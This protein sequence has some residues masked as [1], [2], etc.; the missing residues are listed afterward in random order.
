MGE[1]TSTRHA[2]DQ[3]VVEVAVPP[4]LRRLLT[5]ADRA[6]PPPPT[7]R[8]DAHAASPQPHR[9]PRDTRCS[10]AAYP[11]SRWPPC[12]GSESLR[13]TKPSPRGLADDRSQQ[14]N[15]EENAM[16]PRVCLG[17]PSRDGPGLRGSVGLVF[18]CL[19]C[20]SWPAAFFSI[21]IR[22]INRWSTHIL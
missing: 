16:K 13:W 20:P 15:G 3:D 5:L 19:R 10:R 21:K 4:E 7:T 11:R 2:S 17:C 1:L 18:C 8:P 9:P 22:D 12:A 14:V 6:A